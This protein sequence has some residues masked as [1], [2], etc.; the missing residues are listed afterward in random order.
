VV[1][2]ALKKYGMFLAD[3]GNVTFTAATDALTAHK[4]AELGMDASSLKSLSWNDFE[5]VE[6]GPRIDWGSGSCER[7]P[8]T[9]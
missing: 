5:V 7:T 2:R 9:E 3:G 1:G 6:L 8:I 4:W